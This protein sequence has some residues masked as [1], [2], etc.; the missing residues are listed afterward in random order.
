M[1]RTLL[2]LSSQ[3][4]AKVI[5]CNIS[6]AFNEMKGIFILAISQEHSSIVWQQFHNDFSQ[7]VLIQR[8]L[9]KA[10]LVHNNIW[11]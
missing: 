9:T 8:F 1:E 7:S 4:M 11:L 5:F 3:D 2:L 6:F 10:T